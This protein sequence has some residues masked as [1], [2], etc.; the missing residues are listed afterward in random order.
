MVALLILAFN[1]VVPG[2]LTGRV[3]RDFYTFTTFPVC[4]FSLVLGPLGVIVIT[5]MGLMSGL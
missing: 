3:P 2:I 1:R 4:V 5:F